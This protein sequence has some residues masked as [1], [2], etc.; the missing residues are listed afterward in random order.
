MLGQQ[1]QEKV[2]TDIRKLEGKNLDDVAEQLSKILDTLAVSSVE[3]YKRKAD[4]L[5]MK[6]SNWAMK[7]QI[8]AA[9]LKAFLDTAIANCKEKMKTRLSQTAQK[10]HQAN[11]KEFLH[12]RITD[13]PENLAASLRDAYA[14]QIE[15]FNANLQD[16]LLEGFG[17]GRDE[18]LEFLRENEKDAYD[19]TVQE[20]KIIFRQNASTNLLRKF[21]DDFKKND[22]GGKR[23][24]RTIKEEQ[25]KEIF[26]VSKNR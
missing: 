7:V 2:M 13:L 24:W 10:A 23:D 12:D 19:F 3:S 5:V 22:N 21:N 25:I 11:I 8:H 26:D 14:E 1:A 17:M 4:K 18:V 16:V 9:T 20:I 15:Q 6:G